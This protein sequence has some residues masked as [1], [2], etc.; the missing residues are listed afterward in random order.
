MNLPFHASLNLFVLDLKKNNS[1]DVLRSH[2]KIIAEGNRGHSHARP[3]L[4]RMSIVFEAVLPLCSA[5]NL[6]RPCCA[7]RIRLSAEKA[8][9]L[10]LLL[11]FQDKHFFVSTHV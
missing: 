3:P 2:G 10:G 6:L 4:E 5:L 7:A 11:L 8:G 9:T 1:V